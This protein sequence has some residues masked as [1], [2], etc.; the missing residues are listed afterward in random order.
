MQE[1]QKDF[2][3][4]RVPGSLWKKFLL[5]LVIAD[6]EGIGNQIMVEHMYPSVVRSELARSGD[7]LGFRWRALE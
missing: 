5:C 3:H 2:V 7:L 1:Y 4:A 6:C